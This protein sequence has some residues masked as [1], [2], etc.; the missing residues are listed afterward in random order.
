MALFCIARYKQ[1]T[2]TKLNGEFHIAR[3][4]EITLKKVYNSKFHIACKIQNF[5]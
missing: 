3:F 4:K 1:M 2:L 5:L